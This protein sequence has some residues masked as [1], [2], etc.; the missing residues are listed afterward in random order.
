[1]NI[2]DEIK[3]IENSQL[4]DNTWYEEHYTDIKNQKI[5]AAEHYLTIGAQEGRN[6]SKDFST[7]DY[8]KDYKDILESKCNPL[9]HYELHGKKEG[10]KV[11][12]PIYNDYTITETNTHYLYTIIVASYNY[13]KYINSTLDSIIEQTYKN[14]EIVIVD[15][16]STDNSIEI[17]KEYKNKYN[18]IRLFVNEENKGLPETIKKAIQESKGEFICF[19]ESDDFWDKKHLEILNDYITKHSPEIIVNDVETFGNIERCL[20]MRRVIDHRKNEIIN[21]K[22]IIPDELF[23]NSNYIVTFSA[24]CVKKKL[25]E[26]C[27]I[28]NVPKKTSLDW[29]LWRQIS[30]NNTIHYIDSK[31]TFWRFHDSYNFRDIEGDNKLHD[32]FV[33]E[34][35]KIILKRNSAISISSNCYENKSEDDFKK[36]ISYINKINKLSSKYKS[37]ELL[38]IRGI[39]ILFVSATGQPNNMINDGSVRYRCYHPAEA[40]R[41]LGALVTI[42]SNDFF[43]KNY[44]NEYDIYIFHRPHCSQIPNIK[45]L[46]QQNKLLIAD[47]DDLIFGGKEIANDSSIVKNNVKKAEEAIKI[48]NNNLETLYLFDNFTCSTEQLAKQIG[49]CKPKAKINVIHNFVPQS[50][51]NLSNCLK[52]RSTNKDKEMIMYCSGTLSHNK[53]FE[54]IENEMFELLSKTNMKLVVFGVLSLNQK[55]INLKNVFYHPPVDFWTMLKIMSVASFTIA[56]LENTLFNSCKSNVKFLESSLAG[57]TLI[58][59]SIEDYLR[60]SNSNIVLEENSKNWYETFNSLKKIDLENNI[61][62]NFQYVINNCSNSKFI[63]EFFN[64][65]TNII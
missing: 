34:L 21:K 29:W 25:L 32:K 12:K 53:D 47:Y 16:G 15:D 56:P 1:M 18:F 30:L 24:C 49:F 37:G 63:T 33:K 8:L 58:A 10:R 14:F 3:I 59:S 39:K 2:S 20:S 40:L 13:D 6:P 4:F 23:R 64:A 41:E 60:V 5:S 19:C 27:D 65:V 50:L 46:K 51:I 36:T 42:T 52:L 54:T 38:N 28:L 57:C 31:I 11:T 55:F 61:K 44:T 22:G 35:D 26:T 9:I 7:L 45:K 62:N 17:L 48:F 43:I